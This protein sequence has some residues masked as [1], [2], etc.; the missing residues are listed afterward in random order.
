MY[1]R[2]TLIISLEDTEPKT[3]NSLRKASKAIDVSYGALRYAKN[4]DRD[5]VKKDEKIYEIK[6]C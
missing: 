1:N 4:K 3:F 2:R 6:W 5:F